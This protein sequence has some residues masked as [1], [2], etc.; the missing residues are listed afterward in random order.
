MPLV[1][2]LQALSRNLWWCWDADARAL[3]QSIDDWRWAR[4]NNNPVALLADTPASRFEELGANET[5]GRQLDAV[6]E[7]FQEYRQTPGWCAEGAPGLRGKLVGYFSMEFG[8]HQ[9]LH[10]YSGGLGVLAGDHMKSASDLGIPMVGVSLL[11]HS[12][13]FRQF[14]DEYR[15]VPAYPRADF[16]RLP[17]RRAQTNGSP[18][19]IAIPYGAGAIEADVWLMDVGRNML[20]LLDTDLDANPPE[21]RALT[22]QLYGGDQ[23]TRIAQEVLLGIGGVRAL[24]ALG[25][26]PD[27]FH[28]N[29]GHCAFV[30][31]QLIA[32]HLAAGG[33][34][35]T[36]LAHVR[37]QCV[38]TTHTPVPA[39]H[40]R[41]H[42]ELVD[43]ALGPWRAHL[44]LKEGSLMDLGRVRRG[45]VDESMCMTVLALRSSQACNGVS[46]L[47]GEISRDMWKEMWPGAAAEDVPIGHI[48]NGVHPT[49]WM[50]PQ[51]Q[52]MFDEH[53]P[54]WREAPWDP[55]IWAPAAD[56]GDEVLWSLRADLRRELVSTIGRR[57]GRRL[58]PDALTIGFARRFATYKRGNLVFS[59]VERLEA[60]LDQG[61]Q[62][63]FA[64][65]AHP[66]DLPAQKVLADVV[67]MSDRRRF[68]HRVVFLEDYDIALGGLLTRGSDLWLNNPRRPR[69]AS[70]TSGQKVVLNG[71]LNLSI[72]DGWW[73]EGF[74]GTNGFAIGDER[75]FDSVEAQ[76]AFDLEALYTALE[77]EVLPEW[78]ARD[79]HGRPAAWLERVRRCILTCA[80][81]FTSHRMV[82]DYALTMYAPACTEPGAP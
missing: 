73:P 69:E 34:K 41:F 19:T 15:Q 27:V 56:I 9:A 33:S 12:G 6:W 50:A 3:W 80:P 23:E 49:T 76:D 68:R 79:V 40:D 28:L 22:S 37:S 81:L 57:T 63:V 52:R 30:T 18:L 55:T 44:G 53:C 70:G 82:R 13:Y 62:L 39:G 35:S 46:K 21:H 11:Y 77:T 74:D 45:D 48:T 60:L 61:A 47:H 4:T 64:G 8:L 1:D 24:R 26:K 10:L 72:L 67:R 2:K 17:I 43:Q 36:A 16:D 14:M 38:F 51:A 66:K 65:K 7:R 59:D 54:G 78:C 25:L 29:E 75:H 42:W 71:G 58:D 32:E 20:V 5:F 31:L